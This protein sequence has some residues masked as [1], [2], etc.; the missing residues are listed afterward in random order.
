MKVKLILF[1]AAVSL[2]AQ[3]GLAQSC[4]SLSTKSPV[5]WGIKGNLSAELPSRL[6]N[7]G[8]S[9]KLYNSGFGASIGGLANIYLG[10]NF[11][12][13][14]EVD[15]FYSGYSF[16]NVRQVAPNSPSVNVGPNIYK[17]GLRI[18][19]IVGYF[20]NI[21]EKWGLDVFTGPQFSYAFYG[22]AKSDNE[23]VRKDPDLMNVFKG[24][25]AQ[26]R[27]DLGWKIGVGFP[28]DHF[29]VSLE[30]DLG[31][32]NM[33]KYAGTLRENR[34]SLGITYYFAGQHY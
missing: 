25:Y 19:V 30:A 8:G 14:P 29:L 21:S 9:T 26:R 2:L 33:M 4:D 22:K 6:K 32:T 28:I 20:I 11:Y 31:I 23:D 27:C 12:L 5:I 10:S 13:E 16:N 3:N 17:L 34:L 7:T 1:L 15:L 18:P 24:Y